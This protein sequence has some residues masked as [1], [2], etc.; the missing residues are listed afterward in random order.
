M[1][2]NIQIVEVDSKRSKLT[3]TPTRITIKLSNKIT[4][5]EKENLEEFGLKVANIMGEV[6]QSWRGRFNE[7][8]ILM[9]T[10][11]GKKCFFNPDGSFEGNME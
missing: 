9:S 8:G 6:K 10:E 1:E 3:V 11:H 2:K 7:R 4:Q 5:E